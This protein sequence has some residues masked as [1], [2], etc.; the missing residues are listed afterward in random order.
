MQQ[1]DDERW[2]LAA[3]TLQLEL[4]GADGKVVP[5]ERGTQGDA[6]RGR[7]DG[8][9][10]HVRYGARDA[11]D[12]ITVLDIAL[13]RNLLL[14]LASQVYRDPAPAN[15]RYGVVPRAVFSGLTSIEDGRAKALF[16]ETPHGRELW[17]R[18]HGLGSLGWVELTDSH[19]R[20]QPEVFVD[21][22]GGWVELI[23][24]AVNAARLGESAREE[25]PDLPWET[26]LR[27]RLDAERERLHLDMDR[28]AF[29]LSG[30]LGSVTVSVRLAVEGGRY[31]LVYG[32]R[33]APP[34][35]RGEKL[36]SR[37]PRSLLVRL[38][39]RSRS[40]T[41]GPWE[42]A[43]EVSTLVRGRL[44]ATQLG[45]VAALSQLG[46]VAM[47][48]NTLTFRCFDLQVEPGAILEDLVGVA[49]AVA[50]GSAMPY[51]A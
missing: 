50:G 32:V 39:Q 30:A 42:E 26:R 19:L 18:L 48:G 11:S 35:P 20:A 14:G 3:R 45:R 41:N 22:A 44:S 5:N 4:V 9:R 34:L 6:M 24:S 7:I 2:R 29:V 21:S 37:A 38:W 28:R 8:Y 15:N 23:R 13:R 49:S 51:R 16:E 17:E 40:K 31:A 25:L 47:D 33:F 27:E 10:V 46:H 1:I 43:I 36:A 12:R